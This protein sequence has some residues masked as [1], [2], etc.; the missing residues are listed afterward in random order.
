MKF[1]VCSKEH[2]FQENHIAM[3]LDLGENHTLNNLRWRVVLMLMFICPGLELTT[4]SQL[5]HSTN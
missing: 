3:D 4:K 1:Q 2:Q 5:F